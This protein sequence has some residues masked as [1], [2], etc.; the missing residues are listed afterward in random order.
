MKR[1]WFQLSLW[2]AILL[3]SILGLALVAPVTNLAL[4]QA[5][6]TQASATPT[7]PS[8]Q[9]YIT[10]TYTTETFVNVRAGP[11]SVY[12]GN[13]I[14]ALPT[15]AKAPALAITAGHDWIEIAFPSGP[16]GVGWIYAPFVT[17]TGSPPIIEP[18][19]TFTPI[20]V[21][22]L[23]PAL[24][25]TLNPTSTRLPTFT[26]AAPLTIPTFAEVP[27]RDSSPFPF[28]TLVLGLGVVGFLGLIVSILI[29]R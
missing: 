29:R 10:N 4:A 24:V 7:I 15:G 25:A 27:V 1:F 23:D 9:P 16:N 13:P 5:V 28:G 12:Y 19:P 2:G 26:P 21:S 22:T 17:L 20:A 18:P 11:S 3:A 6:A 14:G 8:L